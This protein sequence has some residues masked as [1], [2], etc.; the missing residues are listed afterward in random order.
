MRKKKHKGKNR[1][2][3]YSTFIEPILSR[4]EK[5][6]IFGDFKER[7]PRGILFLHDPVLSPPTINTF[8]RRKKDGDW[9]IYP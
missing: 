7:Y 1:Y 9:Y 6:N 8:L 5:Y 3:K 2:I 4:S